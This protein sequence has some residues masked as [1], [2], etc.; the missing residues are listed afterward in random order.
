MIVPE[1]SAK[2]D[3]QLVPETLFDTPKTHL[4]EKVF[5]PIVMKQP[6]IVVGPPNSLEYLK[7]YG[8]KTFDSYWDE[9]YDT[10]EDPQERM[11][12]IMQ[13]VDKIS[14]MGER[15]YSTMIRSA[16]GIALYN[17][18]RFF[19]GVFEQRMLEELYT[20]LDNALEKRNEQYKEMPGGT[21]LMY[22]DKL[23]EEG[24]DITDWNRNKLTELAKY[25]IAH[26]PVTGRELLLKYKQLF[27]HLH[28][29]V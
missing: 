7:S 24:Y 29:L 8:F 12:A 2:F 25:I 23:R 10:I 17:R 18:Q 13:V 28:E 6:F 15:E 16:R 26:D 9:S 27:D 20:N 11:N 1:D 4:T 14:N 21:Y 3:I 22:M 5:K 19:G